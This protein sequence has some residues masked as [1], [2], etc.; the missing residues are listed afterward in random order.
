MKSGH[1]KVAAKPEC[2]AAGCTNNGENTYFYSPNERRLPR[3]KSC[4][5]VHQLV[6]TQ[7]GTNSP[8]DF[9]T[10]QQRDVEEEEEE[11]AGGECP[12]LG[13]ASWQRSRGGAAW[14]TS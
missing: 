5:G 12:S 10:Q 9:T 2:V 6:A 7:E 11:G 13:A 8:A 14:K 1:L 3:W 4:P